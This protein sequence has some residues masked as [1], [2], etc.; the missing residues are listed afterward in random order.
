MINQVSSA[1]IK[2]TYM[3]RRPGGKFFETSQDRC[4][5]GVRV[6]ET[7][8]VVF[9]LMERNGDTKRFK[10]MR[11]NPRGYIEQVG[12]ADRI[13]DTSSLMQYAET[14]TPYVTT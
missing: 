7:H 4:C 2:S 9:L 12:D 3:R 13:D 1:Y 11:M 8:D 14:L 10:V 6:E 5:S